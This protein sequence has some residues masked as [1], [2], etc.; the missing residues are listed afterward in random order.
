VP[1]YRGRRGEYVRVRV[2]V[3]AGLAMALLTSISVTAVGASTSGRVP[4]AK[5]PVSFGT[6][7]DVCGPGSAK[8]ATDTGVTNTE[9]HVAT[10]SDPGAS[11]APGLNKEIF[12]AADAFVGWCNAAGGILGRKIVLDK[13]DAKLTD[14]K[15]QITTACSQDVALAGD[16][17]LGDVAGVQ[18]RVDCGLPSF[19]SFGASPQANDADLTYPAQPNSTGQMNPGP[20]LGLLAKTYKGALN[21]FGQLVAGEGLI[22]Q[23]KRNATGVEEGLGG[24]SV[25]L[26][27]Y[28]ATTGE[29][30]W[31]PFSQQIHDNNVSTLFWIGDER[32]AA[33]LLQAMSTASQY[34]KIFFTSPNIYTPTF[35]KLASQYA[36]GH[37]YT[38]ALNVPFDEAGPGNVMK[39]YLKIKNK[40]AKGSPNDALAVNAFSNWLLFAQSAKACGSDL[41]RKCIA[42]QGA[43]TT[44]WDAGGLQVST[45]PGQNQISDCSV[46]LKLGSKGFKRVAPKSGFGCSQKWVISL[47]PLGQGAKA[48]S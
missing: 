4:A 31:A 26:Q 27:S 23:G 48:K 10:I 11:G 28:N 22:F 7:K 36:N 1:W 32:N 2:I 34:P 3:A 37:V 30:S 9:I 13:L 38:Y 21:R 6:L 17:S 18:D 47:P 46:L 15:P 35:P 29:S 20:P 8:G 43:K 39:Q 25:Y 42:E 24:N 16:G 45:N 41:T 44:S 5:G 19:P 14:Y 12:D 40:Y 33:A